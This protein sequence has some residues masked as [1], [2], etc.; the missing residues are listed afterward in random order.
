MGSEQG[1]PLNEQYQK[2]KHIVLDAQ[3]FLWSDGQPYAGPIC[4][5]GIYLWMSSHFHLLKY[6]FVLA[7][8]VARTSK[9]SV[10]RGISFWLCHA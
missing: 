1:L 7:E 6:W 3:Q 9:W 8:G 4:P 5:A 10:G 2:L